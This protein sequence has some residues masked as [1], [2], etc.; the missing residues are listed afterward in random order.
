MKIA[1][2]DEWIVI[3]HTIRWRDEEW[4][5]VNLEHSEWRGCDTIEEATAFAT[6]YLQSRGIEE[7]VIYE[8]SLEKSTPL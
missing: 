3:T 1:Q 6:E 4:A 2:T 7:K 8:E 5:E